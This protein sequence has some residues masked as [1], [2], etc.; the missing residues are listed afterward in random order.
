MVRHFLL[1]QALESYQT[2]VAYYIFLSGILY[3][4]S[5]LH[6][7]VSLDLHFFLNTFGNDVLEDVVILVHAVITSLFVNMELGKVL[8]HLRSRDL[9]DDCVIPA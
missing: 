5:L 6:L 2:T 3:G 8:Y 4:H 9:G 1:L 7:N